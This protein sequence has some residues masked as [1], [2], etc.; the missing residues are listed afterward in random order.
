MNELERHDA[1][2]SD[3]DQVNG[4]FKAAILFRLVVASLS[5]THI[6]LFF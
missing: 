1:M 5:L 4:E 3:D 2:R 6:S